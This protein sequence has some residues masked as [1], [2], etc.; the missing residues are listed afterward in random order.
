VSFN[1]FAA[2]LIYT[3]AGQV[4]AIVPYEVT[5]SAAQVV[6]AYQGQTSSFTVPVTAA[7]PAIFTANSTGVGQ[8][9]AVNVADGTLN[10]ASS[11]VKIGAYI[12][13][14]ATGEG[15]TSPPGMDGKLAPLTLPLPAPVLA[16]QATVGGLPATVVY[17]GAAPGEVAGLM[18]VD[19]LIPSGVQPGS[20][21]PLFIQVGT[22][23]SSPGVSIAVAAN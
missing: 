14:F 6:V 13:I 1:G 2:P 10:S 16:V 5:G 9:A 8:A 11:P 7:E 17:A 18:Q 19:L 20:Q 15:Q 22:A 3:S 21:V 23:L 12:E 4:A